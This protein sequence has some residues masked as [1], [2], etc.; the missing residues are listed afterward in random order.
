MHRTARWRGR[1]QLTKAQRDPNVGAAEGCDLLILLL[2]SVGASLLAKAVTQLTNIFRSH[3]IPV[4][5]GLP[6]M[7]AYQPTNLQLTA[8][9]PIVG[10]SL[11]A[12]AV[13]QQQQY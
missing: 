3:S 7:T 10:A 8:P 2:L 1:A 5:A 9:N 11:L 12:K 6:A 4:G 13:Y